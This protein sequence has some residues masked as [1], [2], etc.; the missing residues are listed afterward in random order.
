MP[1]YIKCIGKT[2]IQ[3]KIDR[4]ETV[5]GTIR[6]CIKS[7]K[8]FRDMADLQIPWAK[9]AGVKSINHV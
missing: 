9:I 7:T 8:L 1:K 5:K 2:V 6:N 4:K 3:R